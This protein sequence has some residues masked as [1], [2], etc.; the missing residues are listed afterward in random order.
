V[1][2]SREEDSRV[3][4]P[5]AAATSGAPRSD[6]PPDVAVSKAS[7][8]IPRPPLSNYPPLHL[9]SH[10]AA[11][12]SIQPDSTF[13]EIYSE[14]APAIPLIPKPT[15]AISL[16]VSTANSPARYG[17]SDGNRPLKVGMS[18][19]SG[20]SVTSR[21]VGEKVSAAQVQLKLCS[22]RLML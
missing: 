2:R 11:F 21:N 8:R 1:G 12:N 17:K 13:A 10:E 5:T 20:I 3:L 19:E 15:R 18:F 22:C 6:R 14:S 4:A 9:D 16:A 7:L